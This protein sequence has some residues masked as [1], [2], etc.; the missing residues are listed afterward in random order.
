ML[1]CVWPVTSEEKWTYNGLFFFLIYI[2]LFIQEGWLVLCAPLQQHPSSKVTFT[3]GRSATTA[4]EDFHW[5]E[6]GLSQMH[7]NGFFQIPQA[8]VILFS[9]SVSHCVC[10][11]SYE[12][13]LYSCLCPCVW[14]Q[15]L[16]GSA[17]FEKGDDMFFPNQDLN[18]NMT[19]FVGWLLSEIWS[20]HINTF[21]WF[22]ILNVDVNLLMNFML[23][24]NTV[25]QSPHIQLPYY[26]ITHNAI[27]PPV[28]LSEVQ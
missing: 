9:Q 27:S 16:V 8:L 22:L 28:V 19:S 5:S 20:N 11:I 6:R 2:S 1:E 3:T 7:H 10:F 13:C 14:H 4:F 26:N 21:F 24:R 23:H 12:T 25:P 18:E 17:P 15:F